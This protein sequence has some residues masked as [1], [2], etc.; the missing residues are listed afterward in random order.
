MEEHG[1]DVEARAVD[2]DA[3]DS[4]DH[5]VGS[6]VAKEDTVTW[7]IDDNISDHSASEDGQEDG[8][9]VTIGCAASGECFVCMDGEPA[10]PSSCACLGRYLHTGCQLRMVEQSGHG[11]CSVC[12]SPYANLII[13]VHKHVRLS[14]SSRLIIAML[15]LSATIF[16]FLLVFLHVARLTG[17]LIEDKDWLDYLL[18]FTVGFMASLS[19]TM[20]WV[21]CRIARRERGVTSWMWRTHTR[22]APSI[23]VLA[24]M[25]PSPPTEHLVADSVFSI[26]AGPSADSISVA[27]LS[28]WLVQRGDFPI[29]KIQALFN[30]LDTD[31]NGSIDRQ[32]WRVG[33]TAG[34]VQND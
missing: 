34:L 22:V 11:K 6:T 9:S 3:L 13:E 28:K 17:L 19:L 15:I 1:D 14:A 21:V 25:G 7:C 31:G 30:A 33:F 27:A 20:T 18:S 8:A 12:K 29:D 23:F 4:L 32:E 2:A 26:V 24:D 10:P 16:V 5:R